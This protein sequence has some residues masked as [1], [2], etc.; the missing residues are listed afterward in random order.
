[1]SIVTSRM[2]CSGSRAIVNARP[3]GWNIMYVATA[4]TMVTIQNRMDL[5]LR[6]AN[7]PLGCHTRGRSLH[8]P[9]DR[10]RVPQANER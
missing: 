10:R 6:E 5:N 9:G 4:T 2:F 7:R 8:R 1:V 3:R